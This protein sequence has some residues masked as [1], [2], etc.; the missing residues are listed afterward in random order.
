MSESH[1]IL[2]ILHLAIGVCTLRLAKQTP[3]AR[4]TNVGINFK[5]RFAQINESKALSG[6]I[7]VRENRDRLAME[8]VPERCEM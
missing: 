7:C 5:V 3:A 2:E 1:S 4:K 8:I 6:F